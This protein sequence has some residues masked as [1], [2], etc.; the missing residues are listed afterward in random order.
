MKVIGKALNVGNY[1]GYD[2]STLTIY[3]EKEL[4]DNGDN[5]GEGVSV[6]SFKYKKATR[7]DYERC[8][9]GS[10]INLRFDYYKNVVSF[11]CDSIF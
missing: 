8:V 9:I 11:E 2:Y 1:K 5:L 6:I 7:Q 10:E 4:R 3:C